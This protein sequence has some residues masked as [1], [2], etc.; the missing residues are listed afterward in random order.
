MDTQD[1]QTA[2]LADKDNAF[3]TQH[4]AQLEQMAGGP[5]GIQVTQDA[6]AFNANDISIVGANLNNKAEE[7]ESITL[8]VDKPEKQH[9]IPERYNSA[10]AVRFS[11]TLENV[12]DPKH[13]DVPVKITLPVPSSINP[14]FLVIMHYDVYGRHELIW[15]HVYEMN[16]KYYADFVLTSF[17]DFIMTETVPMQDHDDDNEPAF[18]KKP[19]AAANPLPEYVVDGTW[20]F[21]DGKWAFTDNAGVAY[22]N[23]WAAVVNPYASKELGHS[24]FDWFFFDENG[25]ML[26]GWAQDGGHWYYL[27]PTSDGTQGRMMTG[28]VLIDGKWYY[29]NPVS[30]GTKGAMI[31]NTWIDKYYVD[32]NGVWDESKTK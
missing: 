24:E 12:E 4:M 16:G 22:K 1:L 10:V 2:L 29:L 27:N 6:S 28:W 13:L 5:A 17:S 7:D 11:M 23:K 18:T 14:D 21:T 31:V 19:A 3:A 15:P 32:E 26:T 8:I 25:H 9:V 30:D 20:T